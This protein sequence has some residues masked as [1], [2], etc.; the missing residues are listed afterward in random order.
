[1]TPLLPI[2]GRL[3]AGC[4]ALVWCALGLRIVLAP[5]RNRWE[6]VVDWLVGGLLVGVAAVLGVLAV[7][8]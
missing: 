2:L 6:S 4:A 5:T 7:L 3:I 1:M 8:G